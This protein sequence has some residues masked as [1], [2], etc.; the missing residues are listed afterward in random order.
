M[1]S[2]ILL[3]DIPFAFDD[4]AFFEHIRMEKGSKRS[5]KIYEIVETAMPYIR[6]VALYKRAEIQMIDQ[7]IF[8]I[9]GVACKSAEIV[10]IL[11]TK[12]FVF[13]NIVSCGPHIEAFC[14]DRKNVLEQYVTMELCNFSCQA[15]REAMIADI[16]KEHQLGEGFDLFPGEKGWALQQGIQIFKIFAKEA[17]EVGLSISGAGV[18][19]PSR[20]AYGLLV[21]N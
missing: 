5:K 8:T 15:A 11:R 9:D 3:T 17:K 16:R 7:E 20:T 12:N 6:P 13:P 2:T 18:P 4:D 21:G 1:N 19:K 14:V 10:E